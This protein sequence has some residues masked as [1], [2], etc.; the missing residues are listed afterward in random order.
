METGKVKIV[1]DADVLIHFQKAGYMSLLP[2]I[3]PEYECIVLSVIY[4]EVKSIRTQ[5]DTQVGIL[6]NISLHPF[7]PTGE[8]A[9]EYAVLSSRFGRGESACMA[10]CRFNHDILGSSNL[11]D[12]SNYCQQNGITYLTTI[13]FL[14]YAYIRKKMTKAE[15]DAFIKDV[16]SKGSKLPVVDIS[17]YVCKVAL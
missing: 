5:L 13:D 12:I 8:M 4:E 10:Y 14:Y 3:L 16:N 11:R 2:E 7:A 15:C 6:K 1:L 17:T 9:R